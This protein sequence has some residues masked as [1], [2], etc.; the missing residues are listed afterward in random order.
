M[1]VLIMIILVIN[2]SE[3]GGFVG[4]QA[5]KILVW[6]QSPPAASPNHSVAEAI[7]IKCFDN[8]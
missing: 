8:Y 2:D 1:L 4:R 6:R 5:L 7:L 3:V